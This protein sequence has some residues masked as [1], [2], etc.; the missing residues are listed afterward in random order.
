[1][2]DER[3]EDLPTRELHHRAVRHAVRHGDVGFLWRLLKAIPV[4][5]AASGHGEE[6]ANDLTRVAAL[7][8]DA[9]SAGEGDVGEALRPIY[10]EYLSHHPDA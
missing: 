10:L 6:A 9:L 8:S 3:L 4:A 2:D 5:E 7:I 1:M